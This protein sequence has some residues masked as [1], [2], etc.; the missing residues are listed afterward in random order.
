MKKTFSSFAGELPHLSNHSSFIVKENGLEGLCEVYSFSVFLQEEFEGFFRS[1]PAK[2]FP[3]WER[4]KTGTMRPVFP[5][6]GYGC[7]GAG[8]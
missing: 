5:F 7:G 4:R 1:F 6:A 2:G 8:Y 3:S